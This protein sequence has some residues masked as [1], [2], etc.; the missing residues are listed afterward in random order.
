MELKPLS[1]QR[2]RNYF[3][4]IEK[5]YMIHQNSHLLLMLFKCGLE[6]LWRWYK[7]INENDTYFIRLGTTV[8]P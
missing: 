3:Q 6:K 8:S 4:H 5:L 2:L 7:T 1:L